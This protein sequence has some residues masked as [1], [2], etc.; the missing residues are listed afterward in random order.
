MKAIMFMGFILGKCTSFNKNIVRDWVVNKYIPLN[1]HNNEWWY[2]P[3]IHSFGN[4]G[5]LGKIHAKLA[6][7]ITKT[8]D[9]TAY[10]G[11]DVRSEV[12]DLVSKRIEETNNT[13]L[14]LDFGCG[15]G[16]SSIALD[17]SLKNRFSNSQVYG[18]DTSNEMLCN[19][20]DKNN[21][22]IFVNSNVVKKPL[23]HLN[24]KVD[25]I[26]IMFLLHEC[27]RRAHYRILDSAHELLKPDGIIVIADI[28]E[29]YVPSIGMLLGEP[30]VLDYQETFRHTLNDVLKSEKFVN[31]D[32]LFMENWIDGHLQ[33]TILR[34][35]SE[36]K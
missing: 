7:Y 32:S 11:R 8:I 20:R 23:G 2:N 5:N 12:S 33:V 15:V 24:G 26:T 18:L 28:S 9:V 22:I 13:V 35:N 3:V 4:T 10:S 29:T 1:K 36:Y 6:P 30:Y 19:K 31:V 21:S 17:N 34:K 25:A 27:P 16:I 14:C